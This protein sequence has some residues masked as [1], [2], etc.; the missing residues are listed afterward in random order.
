MKSQGQNGLIGQTQLQLE[1][2]PD[3]AALQAGAK[4][5]GAGY[6]LLNARVRRSLFSLVPS[7][8]QDIRSDRILGFQLWKEEGAEVVHSVEDA[9]KRANGPHVCVIGGAEIYEL[10]LPLADRIELTEIDANPEGDA[11]V[12]AFDMSIWEEIER[13]G[14]EAEGGAPAFDFVTLVRREAA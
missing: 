4:R 8:R 12:P 6:P 3:I 14:H 10:F 7:W 11:S 5:F 1:G 13:V 9:L 2:V